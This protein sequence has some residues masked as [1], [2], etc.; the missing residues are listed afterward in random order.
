MLARSRNRVGSLSAATGG[1]LARS[2]RW[3]NVFA[4]YG[5][6]DEL[7]CV[8]SRRA[9]ELGDFRFWRNSDDAPFHPEDA[10]L[11]R[12]VSALLARALRRRAAS[13]GGRPGFVPCRDGS[14]RARRPPASGRRHECRH[15]HGWTR[16]S[17]PARSPMRFQGSC[18][19]S[20]AGCWRSSAEVIPSDLRACGRA[21][22]ADQMGDRRG[23]TPRRQRRRHRREH[24]FRRRR[25]RARS[26]RARLRPHAARTRAR[27]IGAR[28]P[29]HPR[30]RPAALHLPPHGAGPPQSGL[31][32]DRRAKPAGA[33]LERLRA[34]RSSRPARS[35]PP[36][37]SAPGASDCRSRRGTPRRCRTGARWA[38]R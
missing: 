19:T 34:G 11:M 10:K 7:A 6:G 31:R 14:P 35:S 12:D 26:R 28:G 5:V 24:P 2:G 9:R 36:A 29:R 4:R 37:T 17:P 8:A 18:G 33:R 25:R 38:P 13:P 23:R 15:A 27:R 32:E 20:S 21:R 3:R 22:P 30:A 16:S 1:D